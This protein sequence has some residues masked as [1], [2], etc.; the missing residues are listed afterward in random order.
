MNK[1]RE[2]MNTIMRFLNATAFAFLTL[3]AVWQVI[4]RYVFNDP[5]TWSEELASY[6]FAWVTLLGAAYVFGQMGHMNI[7]ILNGGKR[8]DYLCCIASGMIQFVCIRTGKEKYKTLTTDRI[9]IHPGSVMFKQ[10]PLY[11]VA[12]EI[13]RTS[14]MYAMSVSPL[15]K[16]LLDQISKDLLKCLENSKKENKNTLEKLMNDYEK[17]IEISNKRKSNLQNENQNETSQNIFSISGETFEVK[18]EKGSKIVILPYKKFINAI[19]KSDEFINSGKTKGKIIYKNKFTLL[20]NE[21][22]STIIKIARTIDL[23]PVEQIKNMNTNIKNSSFADE[24]TSIAKNILKI[25][26]AKKKSKE[27]GFICL[28]TDGKGNYWS[29][30]SRGLSTALNESLSSLE[31]L[32]DEASDIFSESQKFI[33]NEAYRTVSSLFK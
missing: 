6:M 11:F 30:V 4:T 31:K 14:R 17:N 24:I 33:I 10:D 13:V 25:T 5:S 8:G 1:L 12:G 23:T 9:S 27:Y 15:T 21:K 18:A 2:V 3:L 19:K 16:P 29:K 28:F 20:K 26:V 7:P 32:S 22:I